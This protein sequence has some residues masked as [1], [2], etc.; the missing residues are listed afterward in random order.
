MIVNN[1]MLKLKNRDE[2][3]I[4]EAKNVLLS[5]KGNIEFLL[6][7]QVETN[8]RAG[9]SAY[10]IVLIAKY[11][12]MKDLESYL[13]HPKHVEVGKFIGSVLESQASVCYEV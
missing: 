3:S 10:D 12:S 7:L 6:D 11:V 1:L 2:K 5:M 4:M 9:S 8:I 13:A